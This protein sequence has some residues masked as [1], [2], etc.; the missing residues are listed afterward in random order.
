MWLNFLGG[1][2]DMAPRFTERSGYAP[3]DSPANVRSAPGNP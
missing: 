3:S 2:L 1:G